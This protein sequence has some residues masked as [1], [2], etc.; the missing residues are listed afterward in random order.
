MSQIASGQVST[1]AAEIYEE[2]YLPA[3][4]LEWAPRM[5]AAAGVEPNQRVLDVAQIDVVV[6]EQGDG[7]EMFDRDL[8]DDH[9]SALPARLTTQNS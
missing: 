3:L 5:A 1:S 6:P 8:A 4:F 7:V 9:G 2:F